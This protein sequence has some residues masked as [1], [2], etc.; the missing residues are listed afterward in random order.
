PN[1]YQNHIQF[2]QWWMMS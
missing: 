2:K 1:R